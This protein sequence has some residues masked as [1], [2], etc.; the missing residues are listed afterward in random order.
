M[1]EFGTQDAIL[2]KSAA[3]D[4]KTNIEKYSIVKVNNSG[5]FV[6]KLLIRSPSFCSG[7]IRQKKKKFRKLVIYKFLVLRHAYKWYGIIFSLFKRNVFEIGKFFKGKRW[8]H[9]KY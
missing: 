6:L 5:S 9:F 2:S 4:R 3:E 7:H 8:H 1:N